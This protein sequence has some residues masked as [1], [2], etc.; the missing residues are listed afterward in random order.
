MQLGFVGLGKMGS[1]NVAALR[2]QF[3]GH[4]IEEQPA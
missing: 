3:G 4:A 1:N 2:G